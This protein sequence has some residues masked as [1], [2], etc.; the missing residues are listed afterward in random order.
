MHASIV[1]VLCYPAVSCW[2]L[3]DARALSYGVAASMW[4]LICSELTLC[5]TLFPGH[6]LLT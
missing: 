3:E 1:P 2:L 5:C 4:H 6:I